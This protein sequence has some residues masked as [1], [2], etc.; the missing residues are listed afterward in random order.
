MGLRK[1]LR[2][3]LGEGAKSG[4]VDVVEYFTLMTWVEG[5]RVRTSARLLESFLWVVEGTKEMSQDARSKS[6]A[7]AMGLGREL[8]ALGQKAETAMAAWTD[9]AD[10]LSSMRLA[11]KKHLP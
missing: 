1:E 7:E 6:A 5:L 9:L 2:A 10:S 11:M 8:V 4:K 3:L